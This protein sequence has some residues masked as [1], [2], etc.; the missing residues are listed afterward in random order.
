MRPQLA[1]AVRRVRVRVSRR[2][3]DGCALYS[4]LQS[5]FAEGKP[6]ELI[7]PVFLRRAVQQRILEQLLPR[8]SVKNRALSVPLVVFAAFELPAVPPLVVQQAGVVVALVEVFE[9]GGEDL[10]DVVGQVDA[11]GE[12]FEEL[13]AADCGEEGGVG[14]DVFVG[15]EEALFGADAEGYYWGSEGAGWK[16]R[17]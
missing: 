1:V 2:G 14:E 11:F 12:G 16:S 5:L 9:H 17:Q 10:G 3:Q 7:E 4:A 13:A 8:Q 15:G 6:L